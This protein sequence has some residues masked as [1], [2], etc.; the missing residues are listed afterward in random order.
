MSWNTA[1]IPDQSGRIAVVTGANSGIGLETARALAE[2]GAHVV[3]ACRNQEKGAAAVEAIRSGAADA[4]LELMSLD[5]ASLDSI[6]AFAEAFAANHE[7]LDILVNNAGVMMTPAD[8]KTADGFEMQFGTNHLGHFALTGLLLE[9]LLAAP[10]PR[11]V[12]VSSN[13]HKAGKIDF[14]NLDAA[15]GYSK[16]GAYCQSKLANLLF[17]L[18]LQSRLA[19]KG[20]DVIVASSH[21]GWASTNLMDGV[22][23]FATRLLAQSS[24]AGALPS[25]Y[26]AT[27]EDVAS[28]EYFGPTW[29]DMIGAPKRAKTTKTAKDADTA[30]RLW[31]VSQELTGVRYLD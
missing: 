17:S 28:L 26:A 1:D 12:N 22:L 25:L 29:F 23:A 8:A 5:L 31:T 13:A 30:R 24:L 7:R 20:H 15:H 16:V 3:L 6:R 21:P 18:E 4:S 10:K 27:A 9:R 14:D 11:V 2:R 19:E